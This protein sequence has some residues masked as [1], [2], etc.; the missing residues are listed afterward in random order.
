MNEQR[1]E[2]QRDADLQRERW[3]EREAG[4][5]IGR[6]RKIEEWQSEE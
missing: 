5:N 2:R 3:R 6:N 1:T 4:R